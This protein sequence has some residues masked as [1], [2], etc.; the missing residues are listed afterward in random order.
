L[1]K[2][3]LFPSAINYKSLPD[4]LTVKYLQNSA[5]QQTHDAIRMNTK[6]NIQNH[7]IGQGFTFSNNRAS[8]NDGVDWK[9]GSL[10]MLFDTGLY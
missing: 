5:W 2:I 4:N 3:R 6:N 9:I 1:G 7:L 10:N 8:T